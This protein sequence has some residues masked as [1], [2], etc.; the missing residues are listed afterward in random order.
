MRVLVLVSF[1]F[2]TQIVLFSQSKIQAKLESLERQRFEAMTTKNMAFLENVLSDDLAYTHSNGLF[3]TK[4][5]H[6]GS[7]QSGTLVYKSMKPEDLQIRVYGKFAVIT[8]LV[9]VTGVLKEKDF[10]VRL[11]YTDFYVKK[12]GRWQLAAWQSTRVD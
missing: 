7:I 10:A 2:S 4:K 5:E 3:E 9:N 11:R 8:G 12:K 6:V 1:L